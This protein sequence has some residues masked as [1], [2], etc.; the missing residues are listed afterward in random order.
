MR[1]LRNLPG[2]FT[3]HAQARTGLKGS[4]ALGVVLLLSL[5]LV[6]LSAVGAPTEVREPTGTGSRPGQALVTGADYTLHSAQFNSAKQDAKDHSFSGDL[7]LPQNTLQATFTSDAT[8]AQ[9]PFTDVAPHWWADTGTD[10]SVTVELRTSSDGVAWSP[11]AQANEE[12]MIM[13]QDSITQTYGGLIS[14]SQ[15]GNGRTNQ[16]VQSRINLQAAHLGASPVFHELTYTF[17]NSGIT[18]NPPRPHVMIQGTPADVPKPM[19]VPRQEWGAPDGESSPTWT[20]KYRRVTHIIIHHT[21]TPNSDG[22]YA[23]RVRAVWYYHAITRGWGD[24]GYNYVIDPDGV[25]Y[26]GRA[27]GDDVEAGHAYPFNTGS[28]GIGML[29]NFMTVPPSASA[30][31]ALIDLISWKAAQRGIDPQ[32]EQPITGY[33]DCGGTVTYIRPTIAG[34]RD[35]KGT[36]CGKGFNTSTCPGD[37]LHSMLPQIRDSIVANQPALRALFT[38]HDT[39]GNIAPGAT[40]NVHVTVRNTGA[41]TWPSTGDG[42]VW[43]G[44]T[45]LTA[46]GKALSGTWKSI[47]TAL[48]DDVPF[49]QTVIIPA[50]LA[51]PTVAGHYILIWDMYKDGDGWFAQQGSRPLRVDV[52]IGKSTIDKTP[53][54][55]SV[56]PLPLWSNNPEI[57]V[58]WLGA[59]EP[60]GSGLVSYDIE[61]RIAPKGSWVDWQRATALTEAT[62]TGEDGYTYEFR[63]R[64][65]DAAGNVEQWQDTAQAY[66]TIDTR[67]PILE[68]DAPL[69]GARVQPG[70]LLVVGHTEPGAFIAVNDRRATEVNGVFTSTVDAEGRD[71]LIHATAADAAGNVSRV[72]VTVQAAAKYSDVP[73]TDPDNEAVEYMGEH[74]IASGYGDGT[75]KPDVPVT[76]AQFAK[77]LV[78]AMRWGLIKPPEG[79][80]SDV[81]ATTSPLYTYIETAAARG[82]LQGF[83]DGTFKPNAPVTLAQTAR[84]IVYVAG[85]KQPS[86]SSYLDVAAQHGLISPDKEGYNP[87]GVATRADASVILYNLLT[88]GGTA[89]PGT[90]GSTP[91]PTPSKQKPDPHRGDDAG[92]Q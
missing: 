51:V 72:E 62:F 22:D 43:L 17:I 70:S 69:D 81:S 47:R 18:P 44:Y 67:P 23:A 80:F 83:T 28:M 42:V 37:R 8:R 55:S 61:Y 59:D 71:F 30:Q 39:P 66:T 26:E 77:M 54:T 10:T 64:A 58:R 45:W 56:L 90:P 31:S 38:N 21:A 92:P 50:R 49:G 5:T 29:G 63:S 65:R 40:V 1:S 68:I 11:W 89:A 87:G 57:N 9:M 48:P 82:A 76:R 35:Y 74:N 16:F 20:P 86:G 32:A 88:H 84:S 19:M 7:R 12:D 34:H 79:R 75:F 27:G 25:I 52:V 85:W 41:H 33:T 6:P 53:P 13:A 2:V 78:T 73:I 46:D 36:A 14:V 24:I 3:R 15:S 60:K 4:L 91:T